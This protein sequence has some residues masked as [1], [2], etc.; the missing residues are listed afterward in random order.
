MYVSLGSRWDHIT[1]QHEYVFISDQL[2]SSFSQES[3]QGSPAL[4]LVEYRL[5]PSSDD[6]TS[7]ASFPCHSF[8]PG[9]QCCGVPLLFSPG[10]QCCSA[11]LLF[12]S[13]HQCCD[14]SL[15]FPSDINTVVLHSSF[16][17]TSILWCSTPLSLGHQYCGAPLL[18]PLGHQCCGASLFCLSGDQCCGA[19]LFCL[20]GDQCCGASLFCLSGDQCCG[21]SLFCQVINAVVLHSLPG[22]QCCGASLFCQAIDAVVLHSSVR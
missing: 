8:P 14:F 17:R 1:R 18:F 2:D 12:P 3:S 9:N 7:T 21:A 16:P 19:S 5:F 13:H 20:S 6:G 15:F 4:V 10:D 22:D 11:L